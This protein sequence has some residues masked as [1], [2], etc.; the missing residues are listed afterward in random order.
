[1]LY[2]K[3]SNNSALEMISCVM[4]ITYYWRKC[5]DYA[6]L[7]DV[8]LEKEEKYLKVSF[9]AFPGTSTS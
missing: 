5:E 7:P 4:K 9:D 6:A 3:R 1:M 8:T 2:K